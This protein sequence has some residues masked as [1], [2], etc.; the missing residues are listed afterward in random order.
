[1]TSMEERLAE[2]LRALLGQVAEVR[3]HLYEEPLDEDYINQITQPLEFAL[4][5]LKEWD[6][7]QTCATCGGAGTIPLSP[8]REATDFEPC[9]DCA[10][11]VG[12][13]QE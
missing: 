1:M 7:R 10:V 3:R 9:P 5:V 8:D 11:P 13:Q 12:E 4:A 6:E 2:A